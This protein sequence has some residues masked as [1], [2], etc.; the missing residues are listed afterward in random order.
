M[1]PD[2][3]LHLDQDQ[4]LEGLL[5]EAFAP[6]SVAGGVPADLSRRIAAQTRNRLPGRRLHV[7]GRI[8]MPPAAA[9]PVALAAVVALALGT[10][11]WIGTMTTIA[12]DPAVVDSY[13]HS[14][15]IELELEML[16]LEIDALE[17]LSTWQA[18]EAQLDNDL[19]ELQFRIIESDAILEF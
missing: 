18:G 11:A 5:D 17:S 4:Q 3:G 8:G 13:V 10:A 12:G 6:P 1:A 19:S 2:K 7:L 9:W 15:D 16:A 14:S